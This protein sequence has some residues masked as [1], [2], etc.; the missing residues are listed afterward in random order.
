MDEQ[1]RT[2]FDEKPESMPEQS[3]YAPQPSYGQPS[4][5]P[6]QSPY[7]PQPSYGQ[8]SAASE[9]SPYAPQP[10]YGQQPPAFGTAYTPEQPSD[11]YGAP[12]Y[13]PYLVQYTPAPK[14]APSAVP[15]LK[16]RSHLGR[17][18]GIIA[19][20]LLVGA[21][22]TCWQLGLFSS[23]NGTYV[24][25]DFSVFGLYAEI[26]IDGDKAKITMNRDPSGSTGDTAYTDVRT[27][28]VDVNFTKDTVQF[29][30]DDVYYEC[31]YD[32]KEGKII[33]RDDNYIQ[34]DIEFEKK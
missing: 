1:I 3:P 19:A 29:I 31:A 28:E 33:A 17:I 7:A 14:P 16:K 9:Q 21:G 25:D 15:P 27:I 8:P 23:K 4:A 24:W 5:T 20:V 2:P 34:A 22:I 32:R 18:L 30:K 11:G 12:G 26:E 6:E 13:N 10:S